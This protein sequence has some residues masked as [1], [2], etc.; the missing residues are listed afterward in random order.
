MQKI[1]ILSLVAA[2]LI[3][4]TAGAFAQGYDQYGSIVGWHRVAPRYDE[5]EHSRG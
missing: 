4:T 1:K 2:S 3:A 5:S